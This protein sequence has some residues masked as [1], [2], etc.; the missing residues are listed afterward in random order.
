MGVFRQKK[1]NFLKRLRGWIAAASSIGLLLMTSAAMAAGGGKP[2]TKLVNVA[3]TRMVE[4][5]FSK[6]VADIYNNNYWLYGLLVVGIM[7]GMGL[8]L[9]LSFDRLIGFLGIDLGKLDHH[10]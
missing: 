10:E 4:P 1:T 6:W 2:A 8:V 5:G 3:D 9:G 7:A